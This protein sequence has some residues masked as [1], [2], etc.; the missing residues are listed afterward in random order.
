MIG[1][2]PGDDSINPGLGIDVVYAGA[3][4]DLLIL[5][6]SA[7]DDANLRGVTMEGPYLRRRDTATG[8]IV[9]DLYYTE[10]EHAQITGSS[11]DDTFSGLAGNDVLLGGGGNDVIDGGSGDDLLDGGTGSDTLTGGPGND[12]YIVDQIAD[13]VTESPGGGSDTIYALIDYPLPA[14]AENVELGGRAITVTGNALANIITGNARSNFIDGGAGDD[15]LTGGTGIGLAGSAEIDHLI[16][17]PGADTFILGDANFRYY[18]DRSSLTPGTGGYA[19]IGDFTPSAGDKLQLHGP[20]AEYLLG[21]SPVASEP[22]AALYHDTNL[23]GLLDPGHDELIAILDSPE[24]LT[25]ANV[26]M[27]AHFV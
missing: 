16:G 13:I 18:D 11:K 9:D 22:G 20:A 5:D 21:S 2:G 26:I 12:R 6:Y 10:F 27:D 14:N 25:H 24:A 1:G 3:G 4:N 17:G 19:K 15:V 7:G 8:A 23:D